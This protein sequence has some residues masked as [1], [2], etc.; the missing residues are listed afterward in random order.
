M[1]RPFVH[2]LEKA[3]RENPT[4]R[5]LGRPVKG[6]DFTS[7]DYL[8]LARRVTGPAPAGATGSRLLSGNHPLAEEAERTLAEAFGHA[9]GL[10]FPSGYA[11]N[12]GVLSALPRR[13]DLV[14]YDQYA[15]AC[16]K[17]GARLGL[18][19]F[20][21]FRHNDTEDL[22]RRMEKATGQVFVVVESVYSMDGDEAPLA[23]IV[24][25]ARQHGSEVIVD[26]AHATAVRGARGGGISQEL[27]LQD[28]LLATIYT[29]GKGMGGHGAMVAGSGELVRYLVNFSRP[30]IY[31]T[32]LPPA[33]CRHLLEVGEEIRETSDV[34]RKLLEN[35]SLFLECW[36]QEDTGGLELVGSRTAIQAVICPGNEAA[37]KLAAA[38]QAD[39]WDVRPILSPTVPAGRERIRL[40]LHAYNTHEEIRGLVRSFGRNKNVNDE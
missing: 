33:A 30:F 24:R 14:L 12:L 17:D 27:G 11:A 3:L 16:I 40:C 6:A 4:P 15:H 36:E 18:A 8:G 1:A 39:G 38:L 22:A 7:N 2:H 10:L 37:R 25:L 28:D 32:A 29:F 9:Q 5:T 13:G 21:A 31:T 26:E 19:R 34:R 23:E 20:Q 35:I